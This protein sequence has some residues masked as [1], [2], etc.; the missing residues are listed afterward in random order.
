MPTTTI[1]YG[2]GGSGKSAI[3]RLIAHNAPPSLTL[4]DLDTQNGSLNRHYKTIDRIDRKDDLGGWVEE[5]A[6]PAM[7]AG[8]VSLDLG[9]GE[10]DRFLE[11]AE[12]QGFSEM[13]KSHHINIKLVCV[14]SL[15]K[16]GLPSFVSW[17][18][19]FPDYHHVLIRNSG[20]SNDKKKTSK[21]F[22]DLAGRPA[23]KEHVE[24]TNVKVVDFDNL[25]EMLEIDLHN[26]TF[27]EA[28]DGIVINGVSNLDP[29]G[30]QRVS[31][32]LRKHT[33]ILKGALS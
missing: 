23:W 32:W 13:A 12:A 28:L 7:V 29:W 4:I 14:I 15:S 5:R 25:T 22:S 27:A 18:S 31:L 8:D 9:S 6:W 10:V 11:W 2:K 20:S 26:A 30:R 17:R 21:Y 1:V 24:G 16:D 19:V 33:E 3:S